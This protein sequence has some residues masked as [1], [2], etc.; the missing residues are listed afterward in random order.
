MCLSADIYLVQD[1]YLS[2]NRKQL[3]FHLHNWVNRTIVSSKDITDLAELTA[4]LSG[5]GWARSF[6]SCAQLKSYCFRGPGLCIS[7]YLQTTITLLLRILSH[8]E[9][10]PY[11]N[12]H[13]L[14]S[15][16]G[17]HINYRPLTRPTGFISDR[18]LSSSLGSESSGHHR[19]CILSKQK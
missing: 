9:A 2:V 17:T 16:S 6:L 12:N 4:R 14:E 5:E 19:A 7:S 10:N 11:H 1:F 18:I 3:F 13:L 15:L 8:Q